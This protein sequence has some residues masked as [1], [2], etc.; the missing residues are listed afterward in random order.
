M[1][2]K[3]TKLLEEIKKKE[4]KSLN[5][6]NNSEF[7]HEQFVNRILELGDIA[8]SSAN[9]EMTK[10]TKLNPELISWNKLKTTTLVHL[11]IKEYSFGFEVVYRDGWQLDTL[12]TFRYKS[13]FFEQLVRGKYNTSVS[14]SHDDLMRELDLEKFS[15]SLRDNLETSVA[16]WVGTQLKRKL[17]EM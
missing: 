16:D 4:E 3:I 5:K 17:E 2:E 12:R 13:I 1:L 6:K 10:Y 11:H 15:S 14:Q 9:S 7:L 8:A